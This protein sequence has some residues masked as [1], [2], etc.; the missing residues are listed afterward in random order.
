MKYNWYKSIEINESVKWNTVGIKVLSWIWYRLKLLLLV[1]TYINDIV[2]YDM[3]GCAYPFRPLSYGIC[4]CIDIALS[5]A[6]IRFLHNQPTMLCT[7]KPSRLFYHQSRAVIPDWSWNASTLPMAKL[8]KGGDICLL[9]N[10]FT[11]I[12]VKWGFRH[13]PIIWA[14]VCG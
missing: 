13:S 4:Q 9:P 8:L 3:Y 11:L 7:K 6:F 12:C 10:R 2:I 5:S 1:G 14:L